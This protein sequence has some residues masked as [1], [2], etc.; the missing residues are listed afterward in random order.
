VGLGS[1][2]KRP[3]SGDGARV[4]VASKFLK[5]S[6]GKQTFSDEIK[7]LFFT[8]HLKYRRSNLIKTIASCVSEA[9]PIAYHTVEPSV[10]RVRKT[11]LLFK[12]S[13]ALPAD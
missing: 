9:L 1:L 11:F 5:K 8:E 10:G 2:K 3:Q 13:I 6:Y 12:R 7:R 4:D